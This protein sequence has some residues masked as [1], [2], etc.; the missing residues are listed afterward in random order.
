[1]SDFRVKH[2]GQLK[3]ET[4]RMVVENR[5]TLNKVLCLSWKSDF[6]HPPAS[7]ITRWLP[8]QPILNNI[9]GSKAM[10]VMLPAWFTLSKQWV[11]EHLNLLRSN[12]AIIS[13]YYKSPAMTQLSFNFKGLGPLATMADMSTF[14]WCWICEISIW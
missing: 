3:S 7:I 5:D 9:L 6:L 8:M 11:I 4:A 12:S 2:K 1:M 10:A 14:R 13:T